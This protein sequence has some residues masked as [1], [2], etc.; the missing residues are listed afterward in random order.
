MTEAERA[1]LARKVAQRNQQSER[2]AQI[3]ETK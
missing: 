2:D 1:E 3:K